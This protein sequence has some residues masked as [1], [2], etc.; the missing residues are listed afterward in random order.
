MEQQLS[1]ASTAIV[2]E[3]I[4]TEKEVESEAAGTPFPRFGEPLEKVLEILQEKG[5]SVDQNP[6][7]RCGDRAL[8]RLG[9][10]E[11]ATPLFANRPAVRQ[12]G[13]LLAIPL[14]VRSKLLEVFLAE[15]DEKVAG[16]GGQAGGHR[17][18]DA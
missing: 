3:P 16:S 11:D 13:V 12:A 14:L 4:P 6:D 17:S 15:Q 7:D 8:A 9:L 10:L 1:G 18:L 2:H 5:F